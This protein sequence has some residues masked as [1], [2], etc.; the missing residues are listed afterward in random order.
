[1]TDLIHGSIVS[2]QAEDIHSGGTYGTLVTGT[3]L[4]VMVW[5]GLVESFDIGV[6]QTYE[7]TQYLAA[8]GDT[9]RLEN[10]RN[11]IIGEELPFS[12]SVYPQKTQQWNLIPFIVG[13]AAGFSDTPDSLSFI[14]EL[15]SKFTVYTGVM[16]ESYKVDIPEHGK[17]KQTISG[18]AG[19]QVAPSV[20]DPL[21]AGSGTHASENVSTQLVWNDVV[22]LKMDANAT[23]STA[24]DHCVGDI[25][26]G[27]TSEIAKIKHPESTLT[28]KICGVEVLSRK[29]EV[30]LTLTYVDQTFISLV[31]AGTKQNIKLKIG[32]TPDATTYIFTGLLWPKYIAKAEPNDLIGDTL[33]AVV[34]QPAF[35]YS[36]A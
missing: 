23:P 30:S 4:P 34:D 16:F 24:I 35:T 6:E 29:M 19:H 18:F 25:S 10:V 2:Y 31:T 33:T 36:T 32:T 1:M 27:F 15:N 12:M 7:E 11:V 8:H 26:F 13:G 17:I 3:G 5:P 21:T 20:T 28:T 22:E 14:K 9:S